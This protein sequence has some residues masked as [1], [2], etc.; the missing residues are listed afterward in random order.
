MLLEGLDGSMCLQTDFDRVSWK[1]IAVT[2]TKLFTSRLRTDFDRVSWKL[3]ELIAGD[4]GS[5]GL[6]TDFDRVSWK[7]I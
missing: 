1:L 7:Q 2:P 5:L 6:R 3:Q 4:A